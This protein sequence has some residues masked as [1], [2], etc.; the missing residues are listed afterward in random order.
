MRGC[1]T[2]RGTKPPN[3]ALVVDFVLWFIDPANILFNAAS[4]NQTVIGGIKIFTITRL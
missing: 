1:E 4:N 2:F 3:F